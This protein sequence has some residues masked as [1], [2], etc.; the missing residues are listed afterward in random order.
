MMSQHIRRRLAYRQNQKQ[1]DN[2]ALMV[3]IK[4]ILGNHSMP[5][6]VSVC[7][8]EFCAYSQIIFPTLFF[9]SLHSLCVGP[10][11]CASGLVQVMVAQRAYQD[12]ARLRLNPKDRIL[13]EMTRSSTTSTGATSTS[14]HLGQMYSG[15]V[16]VT[17]VLHTHTGNSTAVFFFL[18]LIYLALSRLEMLIPKRVPACYQQWAASPKD[19]GLVAQ[20]GLGST[21]IVIHPKI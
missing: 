20:R 13:V 11:F 17:S 1:T 5:L 12:R 6:P 2:F 10:P 7:A 3:I 8:C 19:H 14:K 15:S 18:L 21:F 9:L 4:C 16:N